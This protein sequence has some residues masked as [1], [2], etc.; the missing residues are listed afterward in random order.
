MQ[1]G[2]TVS[3]ELGGEDRKAVGGHI[4]ACA[5]CAARV[6]DIQPMSKAIAEVER[7]TAPEVLACVWSALASAARDQQLWRVLS[8]I[9]R[10]VGMLAALG[11]ADLSRS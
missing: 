1:C 3:E 10:Q 7:E 2:V 5:D 6:V 9:V 4:E 11:P 8:G